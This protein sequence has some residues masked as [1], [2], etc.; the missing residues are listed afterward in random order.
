ME[1]SSETFTTANANAIIDGRGIT[2]FGIN[3]VTDVGLKLAA[4]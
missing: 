2:G 4:S 1:D 3:A